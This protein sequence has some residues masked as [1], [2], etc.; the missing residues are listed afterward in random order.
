MTVQL[1]SSM[2]S[3]LILWTGMATELSKKVF[4]SS[5]SDRK[6]V[7]NFI[8]LLLFVLEKGIFFIPN[9]L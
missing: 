3:K 6:L 4:K 8:V 5:F 9:Y 2:Y 7:P 1:N